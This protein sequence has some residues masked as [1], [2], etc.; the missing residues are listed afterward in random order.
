ML[1]SYPLLAM[2]PK[3]ADWVA[4]TT[5]IFSDFSFSSEVGLTQGFKIPKRFFVYQR[6]A[7]DRRL[8]LGTQDPG[9]PYF[10]FGETVLNWISWDYS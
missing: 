2:V 7:K 1:K 3:L 6:G 10:T 5:K 9:E 4:K 8:G